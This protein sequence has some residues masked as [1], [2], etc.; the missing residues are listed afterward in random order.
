[1]VGE[2][3]TRFALPARA[4]IRAAAKIHAQCRAAQHATGDVQVECGAVERIDAA[5][6]QCLGALGE[7]LQQGA[8]RLE[9]IHPSPGFSRTVAL[10]GFA[11]ILD[12]GHGQGRRERRDGQQDGSTTVTGRPDLSAVQQAIPEPSVVGFDAI[13]RFHDPRMGRVSARILPGEY[14]VTK[15]EEYITTLLGS[16]VAVCVW[17]PIAGIGGMN[18][19][20]AHGVEPGA[21]GITEIGPVAARHGIFAMELLVNTILKHGGNRCRLR[22]K[23]AGGGHVTPG[24]REIGE[25]SIRFARSY[26]AEEGFDVVGE[27]VEGIHP[28]RVVFDPLS[29]WAGAVEITSGQE[30][31]E[32][33]EWAYVQRIAQTSPVG[34]VELF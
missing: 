7:A 32:R 2:E 22:V 29:G 17:D 5:V 16:C 3:P 33:E 27:H 20:T 34:E 1:M 15:A 23:L 21:D 28:R 9:L 4:D 31:V 13:E 6:L 30:S 8:R 19:F 14:Y 25:Q 10:L 12:G 24:R 18:H 11:S 26:L